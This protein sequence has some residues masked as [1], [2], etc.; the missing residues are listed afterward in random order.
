MPQSKANRPGEL[1]LFAYVGLGA[2]AGIGYALFDALSESRI[3]SGTLTGRLAEVHAIVD[4]VSPIVVG[5]LLGVCAHYLRLRDELTA[6]RVAAGRAEGL[7]SRLQKVERDQAVWV[8]SA[9]VLHELNNPLHALGLLLDE[10]AAI[11]GSEPRGAD[12]MARAQ[13]QA[14]RA[15]SHLRGLRGVASGEPQVQR[16]ALEEFLRGLAEEWTR[17]VAEGGLEIR[18]E[19]EHAVLA[20]ADPSYVRTILENLLDNSL[21]SMRDRGRGCIT[22]RLGVE[23][24][25]A[26]V[27]VGDDGPPI[28]PG[29]RDALFEPL[30]TTKA[31]GLGLGLPIARAL[32]RA[33]RGDVSLEEGS[34][35]G[36]AGK[37]FRLELPLRE[38]P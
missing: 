14:D 33:M 22:M 18:V 38:A 23:G 36:G 11:G 25:R 8:L 2:L 7:R 19:C 15:L 35:Q 27:R 29:V 9:A 17:L 1:R 21:G 28:D 5:A 10:L 6:A 12:L 30:R 31:H 24:T 37:I 20:S 3:G 34:G 13:T 32:A 16:I 4:R 26:V